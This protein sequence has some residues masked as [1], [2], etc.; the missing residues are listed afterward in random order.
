MP[1]NDEISYDDMMSDF[2]NEVLTS[3]GIYV[4]DR[5]SCDIW[6]EKLKRMNHKQRTRRFKKIWKIKGNGK[7]C[8]ENPWLRYFY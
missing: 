4:S 8:K 7:K 1:A 2:K 3:Y 5:S 6:F